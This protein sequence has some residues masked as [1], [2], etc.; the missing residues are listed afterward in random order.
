MPAAKKSKSTA[1]IGWIGVDT[2]GDSEPRYFDGT[3]FTEKKDV[4]KWLSDK[5][6][7]YDD[8]YTTT[9]DALDDYLRVFKIRANGNIECAEVKAEKVVTKV[10]IS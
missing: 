6:S 9:E 5:L 4:E 1:V 3:H 8:G 7:T 2:G 10:T